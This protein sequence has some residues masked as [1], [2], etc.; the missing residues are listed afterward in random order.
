[1]EFT[2][3]HVFL[4]ALCGIWVILEQ[5][6]DYKKELLLQK[7]QRDKKY[8]NQL[9]DIFE[10][11]NIYVNKEFYDASI[12]EAFSSVE[13]IKNPIIKKEIIRIIFYSELNPRLRS[14]SEK[15]GSKQ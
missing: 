4:Y 3:I 10:E 8:M 12:E 2:Y 6:W 15:K 7:R 11:Y 9:V 14:L 5:F 13:E 1:M